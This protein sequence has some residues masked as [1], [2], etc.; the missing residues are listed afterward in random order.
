VG[1]AALGLHNPFPHALFATPF[2]LRI[3]RT[4]PVAYTAYVATVYLVGSAYW[5]AWF[6]DGRVAERDGGLLAT[7][8]APGAYAFSLQVVNLDLLAAW[9]APFLLPCAMVAALCWRRL[10]QPLRDI[11]AG[12]GLTLAFYCFFP[13]DQQMGWG[14]R[15]AHAVL[16]NLILLATAGALL[17]TT[18]TRSLMLRR[19][20]VALLGAAFLVQLPLRIQQAES[21]V[22]P[23]DAT[24][25]ALR[26]RPGNAVVVP[27]RSLWMGSDFVRNDP[28]LRSRPVLLG[29]H[30]LGARRGYPAAPPSAQTIEPS[31]LEHYGL[32]V[33]AVDQ[34][35]TTRPQ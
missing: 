24:M 4:R 10:T 20:A 21:F 3:A 8:A 35:V 2:L 23:F 33:K 32:P 17:L 22:R 30:A 5:L 27:T 13:Y 31:A 18:E 25:Q 19:A 11:A 6:R 29:E 14:Y 34:P 1:A 16:G 28:F 26:N 12:V 15:Y 9:S 7:F